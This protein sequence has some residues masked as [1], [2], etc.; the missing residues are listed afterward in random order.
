MTCAGATRYSPLVQR[1][2]RSIARRVG[3]NC[4]RAR[5]VALLSVALFVLSSCS[6]RDQAEPEQTIL[7]PA[8][9][10]EPTATV[11]FP[12]ADPAASAAS[13]E[14]VRAPAIAPWLTEALAAARSVEPCT[15]APPLMTTEVSAAV[16][17]VADQVLAELLFNLDG[18]LGGVAAA[19]EVGDVDVAQDELAAARAASAAIEQR[20]QELAS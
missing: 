19:C 4:E 18:T 12:P 13:I 7:A 17:E 8:T 6:D 1:M 9:S 15:A 11:D 14:Q 20:L 3:L 2:A 10:E 16:T 5:S